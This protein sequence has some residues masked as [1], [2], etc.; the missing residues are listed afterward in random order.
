MSEERRRNEKGFLMLDSTCSTQPPEARLPICRR[1]IFVSG[2][3]TASIISIS[4]SRP[5]VAG[6]ILRRLLHGSVI[7]LSFLWNP[8]KE[9][10]RKL[11]H[12]HANVP[13][14]HL[15]KKVHCLNLEGLSMK[16]SKP[17]LVGPEKMADED[18]ALVE[19]APICIPRP[20]KK[21]NEAVVLR[22]DE[23]AALEQKVRM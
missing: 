21:G 8:S 22:Q 20:Q 2:M 14:S 7:A 4:I 15:E 17:L 11:S 9:M 23:L 10:I 3:I 5:E 19:E 12:P 13:I 18:D 16:L 1:R 6:K